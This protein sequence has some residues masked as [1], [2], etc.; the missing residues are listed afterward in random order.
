LSSCS[1]E[2]FIEFT[3]SS[4]G[5]SPIVNC[6]KRKSSLDR[7]SKVL[8]AKNVGIDKVVVD[9]DDESNDESDDEEDWD[10]IDQANV[11]DD[12]FHEKMTVIILPIKF[13]KKILLEFFFISIQ[14]KVY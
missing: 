6:D 7:N 14:I 10:E 13:T 3:A 11:D 8:A 4:P 9:S 1:D 12:D 2:S 5:E